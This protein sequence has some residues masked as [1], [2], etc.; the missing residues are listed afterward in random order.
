[1]IEVRN[2]H[3]ARHDRRPIG[4]RDMEYIL[5]EAEGKKGSGTAAE[6]M[7]GQLHDDVVDTKFVPSWLAEG[8]DKY[9][10]E[11]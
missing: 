8:L 9:R 3:V 10:W 5:W 11:P 1:M 6:L 4:G 7:E 2:E